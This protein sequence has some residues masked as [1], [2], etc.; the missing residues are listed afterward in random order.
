MKRAAAMLSYGLAVLAAAVPGLAQPPAVRAEGRV[1]VMPL[2]NVTRDARLYWLVEGAAVLLSEDLTALGSDAISRDERLRAFDQLQ[3]PPR[4][5]LSYAT[6]IRVAELVGAAD[7]VIGSLALEG[8]Q[9]TVRARSLRLDTGRMRP[10]IVERGA[11][12]ELFTTFDRVARQVAA[13]PTSATTHTEQAHASLAAFENYIKGLLAETPASQVKF[14]ETALLLHPAY[15]AA[16]IA[17]WQS[18]AAQGEAAKA[19]AV[20]TEVSERSAAYRR[21]R[22]LAALS[23]LQLKRYD[24]A[25][26]T[27]KALAD[28]A[29]SAPVYN[30]LGVVQ[31]RRGGSAQTGQ[32]TYYFSRAA[33]DDAESPDYA[34]NLGY[35]YWFERDP[36][37][38]IYWLREA[39]RRRPSDADAHFVLG[40]AL[41]A[42]GETV[43]GE[44]ELE[45]ARQLSS[46]YAAAERRP[47]GASDAVP[48]GLERL[49]EDLDRPGLSLVEVTAAP[50]EQRD[51]RELAAF[52]LQRG[53][54]LYDNH[55]DREATV[56]L[57][58]SL[59]LSPYQADAHLFLGRI[60][61]RTS[62]LREAIEAA[63]ISIWCQDS[64]AAHVVLGEA[65][66][67]SKEVALA[68]GEAQRAL[69]LDPR[70]AEARQ[71]LE[72]IPPGSPDQPAAL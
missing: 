21:A 4:S 70:S 35:A 27:L 42:T 59:Y 3:L 55:Q 12:K 69:L 7:V 66:L 28:Q 48:R 6:V 26:V 43:T 9:L 30:N 52:H 53:Q 23:Q 5:S 19:L 68:R 32:A 64:A 36:S 67:L 50:R 56:E 47:D 54:R 37:A 40:A 63:K 62:R 33:S 24:E 61:L 45:L 2:E 34:F 25:F 57:R 22:F 49:R 11:L 46:A 20:I 31:L 51:Q 1:L 65:Y 38:A 58:R 60:W 41:K 29:S 8:E 10:E 18:L 39:V 44:R 15:D 14:L 17:L 72:K 16:R 13:A 71:L